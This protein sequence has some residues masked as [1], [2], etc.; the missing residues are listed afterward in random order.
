M[1]SRVFV[2]ALFVSILAVADLIHP[3]VWRGVW[4]ALGIHLA[5]M[6]KVIWERTRLP[7]WTAG[8]VLMAGFSLGVAS[9]NGKAAFED[10]TWT[11]SMLPWGMIPVAVIL[12]SSE[13]KFAPAKWKRV[14]EAS[15]QTG[16]L[17]MLR[18]RHIPDLR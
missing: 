4:F 5:V 8:T 14:S 7:R 15:E 10:F 6:T 3:L 18:F 9:F 12:M 17:G 13:A 2:G 16:L 11:H 1:D